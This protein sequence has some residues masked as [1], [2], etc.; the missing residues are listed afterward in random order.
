MDKK[1]PCKATLEQL[2]DVLEYELGHEAGSK[3]CKEILEHVKNCPECCAEVDTLR[4]TVRIFKQIPEREVPQDV[5]WRLLTEL[6]LNLPA[7]GK[8]DNKVEV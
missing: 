7:S 8:I 1:S 3:A 6:N 2:C 4:K 5:Q